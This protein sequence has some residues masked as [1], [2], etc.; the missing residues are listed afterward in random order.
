MAWEIEEDASSSAPSSSSWKEEKPRSFTDSALETANDFGRAV[1]NAA[2]F[3]MANRAKAY[4]ETL[5]EG[6][7]GTYDAS[8]EDQV[9]RSEQARERSP[10]ASVAGD[11]YGSLA[12]PGFG[13]EAAAARLGGGLLAR[14]VAYGGTGALT[15]ALQGAGGTYTGNPSDYLENAGVGAAI[16]APLG[17]VGGA[18]FGARPRVSAAETPSAARLATERTGAYDHLEQLPA[19]YQRPAFAQRAD[20]V[21]TALR[22]ENYYNA[23]GTDGGSPRTFRT[24]EQMREPP[25]AVSPVNGQ[26][27]LFVSPADIDQ[28]RKG[29]TGDRI[30]GASPTDRA[31]ARIVRQNID[32]FLQNPPPG[33]VV[34]GTEAAAREASTVSRRAHELH[35]GYKRVQFMDEMVAN[36]ERQAGSTHSGLNLRNELQKAVKSRLAEKEGASQFSRAGFNDAERAALDTFTRGQGATSRTLGY[37]DKV[38]GGG[39]GLGALATGV[40]GGGLASNYFKDDPG[41]GA[42]IGGGAALTG[43]ALRLLGNRRAA[44]DINR[45]REMIGQRNPL[46]QA[47]AARAGTVPGPGSRPAAAKAVR[48]AITTAIMRQ[49]LRPGEE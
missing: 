5:K 35:G 46:Y 48:D 42:A 19:R 33:S 11:V 21:E 7:P 16:G 14:G 29:V 12:I 31:S 34:P 27:R 24:V 38:L 26:Q 15:G 20:D 22:R 3:G 41:T 23:P 32:D 36:A 40:G 1:S 9:K 44:G 25:T 47:R 37:F 2:T 17:A 39:G 30:A 4:I 6:G 13:A 8:L 49:A 43:L 28:V 18:M 45:L 10:Y